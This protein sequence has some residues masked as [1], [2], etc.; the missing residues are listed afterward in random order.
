MPKS[1]KTRYS[2]RD[3]VINPQNYTL[4]EFLTHG[5]FD[6]LKTLRIN[7]VNSIQQNVQRTFTA[8]KTCVKRTF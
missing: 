6:A 4:N 3:G 1:A 5:K 8:R 2:K 7:E